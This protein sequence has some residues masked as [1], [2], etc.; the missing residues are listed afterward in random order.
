MLLIGP[1]NL[2]GY[3]TTYETSRLIDDNIDFRMFAII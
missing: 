3:Y 1:V 2:N